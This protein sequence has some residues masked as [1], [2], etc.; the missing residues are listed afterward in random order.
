MAKSQR[1]KDKV[2]VPQTSQLK[3]RDKDEL[4]AINEHV[5]AVGVNNRNLK[6][7][8]VNISQS[9]DLVDLIPSQFIKVSE[10][11]IDAPETIFNLRNAGFRGFLMG[12]LFMKQSRPE[13]ACSNFITEITGMKNKLKT[14]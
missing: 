1:T 11:G 4:K 6:D 13:L 5:D 12:E 8:S 14:V 2:S 7:F 3:V 9:Y 10:S